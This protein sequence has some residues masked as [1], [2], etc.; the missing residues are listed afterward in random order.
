MSKPIIKDKSEDSRDE[1]FRVEFELYGTHTGGGSIKGS[2]DLETA[3]TLINK[4]IDS[5]KEYNEKG[6]V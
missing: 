1:R 4:I 6:K 5:T 3:R 2:Y